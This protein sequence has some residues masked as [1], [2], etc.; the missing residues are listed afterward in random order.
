MKN[1]SIEL[2]GYLLEGIDS[3]PFEINNFLLEEDVFQGVFTYK[4]NIRYTPVN[5]KA[6]GFANILEIGKSL[7]TLFPVNISADQISFKG[8]LQI[9]SV[10][11]NSFGASIGFDVGV[12]LSQFSDT[13]ID[14]LDLGTISLIDSPVCDYTDANFTDANA[15]IQQQY[16]QDLM[17][18]MAQLNEGSLDTMIVC[19]PM[20][21]WQEESN[22]FTNFLPNTKNNFNARGYTSP[23]PTH[24]NYNLTTLDKRVEI[25]IKPC[26]LIINALKLILNRLGYTLDGN[27]L[28][29]QG[30]DKLIH[31]PEGE[32]ALEK[33][34]EPAEGREF[35][36]NTW[37]RWEIYKR[38]FAIKTC[39]PHIT[40]LELLRAL[41]NHFFLSVKADITNKIV[42]LNL[43][44]NVVNSSFDLDL[45]NK[46][47]GFIDRKEI[48][49][50]G[51]NFTYELETSINNNETYTGF[52]F[53]EDF[54][55]FPKLPDIALFS[56]LP[57]PPNTKT[58]VWVN[59]RGAYFIAGNNTWT[60]VRTYLEGIQNQGEISRKF[61]LPP[62]PLTTYEIA[63]GN[64]V[65]QAPFAKE[66]EERHNKLRIAY[67]TGRV[68]K[69]L[70]DNTEAYYSCNT[71]A[72]PNYDVSEFG[73]T[74]LGFKFYK[75]YSFFP[76]YS[77]FV[78]SREANASNFPGKP[79]VY[80]ALG[81][82]FGFFKSI[83]FNDRFKI[84]LSMSE[85]L[86][87]NLEKP[88][89]IG[90]SLYFISKITG[91]APVN[92]EMEIEAYWINPEL[93]I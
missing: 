86:S 10:E 30:M 76:N 84:R 9:I 24:W 55:E 56:Q 21:S 2:N 37:N 13:Y 79:G 77:L 59:N 20:H 38:A 49:R 44:E 25:L 22:V 62:M 26:I 15:Y 61:I 36:P 46:I 54:L 88:K 58:L 67:Y 28:T 92:D 34:L 41:K 78:N 63:I 11:N 16:M 50:N 53:G 60:R 17:I 93:Q 47:A 74:Y 33:I 73:L 70:N 19:F 14:E 83:L 51:L 81:Q 4:I 69:Y 42:T 64:T 82:P 66:Q 72:I 18:K 7:K 32:P 87:M 80:E 40:V 43:F 65:W 39:L 90:N 89:K 68:S 71:D 91:N 1:I 48:S 8:N 85:A 75:Q 52:L 12:V 29:H 45:T 3:F 27:F 57:T 5:L 35:P 31:I 6:F 23:G